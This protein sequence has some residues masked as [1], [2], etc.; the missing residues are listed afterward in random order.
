MKVSLNSIK[1]YLDFE[2]PGTEELIKKINGQLGGVEEASD[3]AVKYAGIVIVRIAECGKHP[4]ADKLSVCKVDDGGVV[5]DVER[6][7]NGYVQVVCGAPNARAGI[8]AVWLPPKTAV[9]ASFDDDELFVLEPRKLRGIMSNGML[10]AADE[11]AIGSDHNGIIELTEADLP[12]E[13]D[14]KLEPGQNFAELFGLNDTNI[15][16]ENKMFT[17][18]P[19][20]FGQIGV[21]REIAGIFHRQFNSPDWYRQKPHFTAASGLDLTVVNDAREKV[22]RFMAVA[23]K[24]ITVKPSPFWLQS[25][26]VRLGGKPINNIVDITNYLMLLTAQPLH[27][28]DYDKLRGGMI[29]ARMAEQGEK[30]ILLN[31]KTYELDASD[32]VISDGEG[33]IGLG[34][35][36]GG[37]ES[38]V[39]DTTTNIVLEC[40]T[41]DM[42]TIRK[43]SMRH[44]LFTDAVTRY[45][46]GQ[47]PLQNDKIVARALHYL[48][49]IAGGERAS[50]VYDAWGAELPAPTSIAVT[51]EFINQRLGTNLDGSRM[52]ALLGNVEVPTQVDGGGAG[53]LISVPFWR[54]DLDLAEDIVEEIGRLEGFDTL[55]RELPM[56]R[57]LPAPC[58]PKNVLRTH[59]RE[60]L[61]RMGANEVLSYSFVHEN[62]MTRAEQ[63][64]SR[65]FTLGNALSPD[66]QYY[67]LSILPSLLDKVHPNSKAGYDEFALFEMG[68]THD[69]LLHATDGDDGLPDE[70]EALELVYASK[71]SQG[72][73]PYFVVRRMAAELAHMLGFTVR[74]R[75]IATPYDTPVA[76]PYNQ[77][78][79]AVVE[80]MNGEEIGIVG[81]LKQ[82]VRR[83]F[84]L[85]EY[86][87]AMSLD[88]E[89]VRRVYEQDRARYR[90]LS[91][92][93]TITNDISLK[94]ATEVSY[95]DLFGVV[96]NAVEQTMGD[97]DYRISPVA[98]YQPDDDPAH[99]TTTFHLEFTSYETTL[100]DADLKPIMQAI[101]NH[102][103]DVLSA[104]TA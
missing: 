17:H 84:K 3:I 8:S 55:P 29:R 90:P 93:P 51:P 73:A 44:G 33:V 39:S 36:M 9:P 82:T 28:Y 97:G 66:L 23:L 13:S 22:P 24:N 102:A 20:C 6:D 64:P 69:K 16:I 32:I 35:V 27:A 99:K 25:E 50:E 47:S 65:A 78:R 91:K 95:G 62:I 18:R 4:D 71:D 98:I 56:R 53:L 1:R 52:A 49:E 7:E 70:P 34:G 26:L 86:T 68:K 103:R 79:S 67:R 77:S 81:E 42:Y 41:F 89:A 11:L 12:P 94:T 14:N 74:F 40:A 15:D 76:A 2:L 58:N 63:D 104:E 92:Y 88:L 100:T 60:S 80:T 21:A 59:I 87:A 46:K 85:P 38:E 19:D 30:T 43:T 72:G 57:M 61:C 10:A 5:A 45:N 75:R 54:T 37:G 48:L 101:A 96:Q 83:N 31:G